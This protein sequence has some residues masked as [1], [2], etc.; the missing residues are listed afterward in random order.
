MLDGAR[1]GNAIVDR[2]KAEGFLKVDRQVHHFD[3]LSAKPGD[4]FAVTFTGPDGLWEHTVEHTATSDDVAAEASALAD[5]ISNDEVVQP[6]FDA[7]SD[8]A[9]VTTTAKSTSIFNYNIKGSL[10]DTA[11]T[12]VSDDESTREFWRSVGDEILSEIKTNA[13]VS[14]T[15]TGTAS[16]DGVEI[17]LD[18]VDGARDG[19]ILANSSVS[20][21]GSGSVA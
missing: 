3:V 8:A 11:G 19:E 18:P 5:A 6:H 10:N 20:G 16:T 14:T 9:R 12:P 1:L 4:L 7:E 2:L 15:V 21:S 17:D 13:E